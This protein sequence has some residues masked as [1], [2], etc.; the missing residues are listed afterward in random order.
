MKV[1]LLSRKFFGVLVLILVIHLLMSY[2]SFGPSVSMKVSGLPIGIVN[3][4]LGASGLN[5][6]STVQ[7]QL[8][9]QAAKEVKWTTFA[10]EEEMK[11][12]MD[13]KALYGGMVI[14]DNFSQSMLS[15]N[16]N[17]P[18]L[19]NL[20]ATVNEGQNSSGAKMAETVMAEMVKGLSVKIKEEL[21]SNMEKSGGQLTVSQ[22]K[23][24]DRTIELD[25]KKINS[26]DSAADAQL[27][28]MLTV[29]L[30]MGSLIGSLMM[31]LSLHRE[32][33]T[34]KGF[35]SMQLA[36]GAIIAVLQGCST[37]LI[38]RG[39]MGLHVVN[40]S[41]LVPFIMLIAFMF[42]LIQSNVLNWLGFKGWPLLILVWLFGVPLISTP[43][44]FLAGFYRYGIYSWIPIRFG[45]EGFKS[46]LFFNGHADF[47]LMLTIAAAITAAC[48][49]LI[50]LSALKLGSKDLSRNP[51][52]SRFN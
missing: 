1:F 37:L 17:Q 25:I 34:A 23:A 10:T 8:T 7:N 14:P 2:A 19:P 45:S 33:Q 20:K 15:L 30:W 38:T 39:L 31:W 13:H 36:G 46:I 6:G 42:F 21:L 24:L 43:P 49:A 3:H 44:E 51:M 9:Q 16:T 40:Y 11:Q 4:D 41:V 29:L 50:L 27:P 32:N 26:A 5:Y 28:T 22:V 52:A 18:I 48:G 35:L 12:E 47:P